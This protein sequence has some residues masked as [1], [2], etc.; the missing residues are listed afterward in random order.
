M[1]TWLVIAL[2][3]IIL[4]ILVILLVIKNRKDE[5]EFEDQVKQDYHKT[6]PGDVDTEGT[7]SI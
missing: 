7:D 1:E 3:L 2:I 6:K 5:K 4:A